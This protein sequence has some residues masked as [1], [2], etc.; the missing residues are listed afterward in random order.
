MSKASDARRNALY[1]IILNE[2]RVRV[3]DLA[4]A[5]DVTTETIRKDLKVLEDRG[6]LIKK[7]GS[8]TVRNAYYQLPFDV[9]L[10]EDTLQKQWIARK[11]LDFIQDDSIVYL[12][13]GS[14]C[15]QLAKL[16][17]LKKNITVLT[18]SLPIGDIICDSGLE[19]IMAGGK[20][21]KKGRA[22]IGYYT[23]NVIDSIRID[24]AFLGCDGFQDM[25]GP[26]TF[27]MEHAEINRHILRQSRKSI[28]L[29]DS[30][31]FTKTSTYQFA[32]FSDYDVMITNPI[33]EEEQTMVKGVKQLIMVDEHTF[34]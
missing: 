24:I 23:T 28:L 19:L 21:Q 5:L 33:S 20:L 1:E 10:Q 14:T 26:M 4:R 15:L 17:R 2:G 22:F 13:P 29:C 25:D 12:D 11:A 30:S 32:K 34:E 8:A 6:V 9:K 7:H 31:K 27:S 16:L 18:N 3:G